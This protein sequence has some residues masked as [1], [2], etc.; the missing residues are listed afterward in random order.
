MNRLRTRNRVGLA[1]AAAF[2]PPPTPSMALSIGVSGVSTFS[3]TYQFANIVRHMSGWNRVSGSGSF[4][5][6]Q[7]EL[8][9][10]VATDFFCA[11]LAN[12]GRGLPSGTY[13]VKNPNGCKIGFGAFNEFTNPRFSAATPGHNA[14][15]F[16]GDFTFEWPG[17]QPVSTGL[18]LLC[19]G[20]VSGVEVL[21]PGH[22]PGE[23]FTSDF[24]AYEQGLGPM[25][26]IRV[27]T[28]MAPNFSVEED[29][30]DRTVPTK[31][32]FWKWDYTIVP[33][34]I[35]VQTAVRFN[36]DIWITVPMRAAN[37]AYANAMAAYFAANLPAH[38]KVWIEYTN[39]AWNIQTFMHATNWV[40]FHTHTKIAAAV[41]STT[42]IITKVAHGLVNDQI[43]RAFS[44][45][46][47][48]AAGINDDVAPTA[49]FTGGVVY[50]THKGDVCYAEVLTPDTFKLWSLP[51]AAAGG[52]FH[53][54]FS[55]GVTDCI[56]VVQDEPG[57]L[58]DLDVNFANASYLMW[59]AFDTAFGGSSR[60][61]AVMAGQVGNDRA[62]YRLGAA[63]PA[64]AAR[65]DYYAHAPYYYGF[66]WGGQV[67]VSSGQLMPKFWANNDNKDQGGTATG[68][69]GV[70]ALGSDPSD[71]E[72]MA[73]TGTGFVARATPWSRAPST[74][75][76]FLSA[77][78][79]VSGLP[80]G[81]TYTCVMA[82]EDP[83]GNVWSVKQN[84]EV[85]AV[86]SSVDFL[87]TYA[88]QAKRQSVTLE[89]KTLPNIADTKAGIALSTR[90]AIPLIDYEGGLHWAQ[91][92]TGMPAPLWNW[93]FNGYVE[94]QE[95]ADTFKLYLNTLAS[96]G[97]KLHSVFTDMAN[98][99]ISWTLASSFTDTTDKRYMAV[100]GLNG[101]VPITAKVSVA[102]IQ[103]TP[104][105]NQ[106]GGYP[107]VV[108]T[109]ADP[110]LTYT[111]LKEAA[112]WR[113]YV[114]V[115][116]E[117]RMIA[118]NGI[119]WLAPANQTI[120]VIASNGSTDDVFEVT[121]STGSAWYEGAAL[122]AVNMTTQGNASA[123]TMVVGSNNLTPATTPGTLSGG[124][125]NMT[126]GSNY[127]QS[128]ALTSNL[129]IDN[130]K[131]T[132]ILVVAGQ[133]GAVATNSPFFEIGSSQFC[134]LSTT[135]S[136]ANQLRWRLVGNGAVG[137]ADTTFAAFPWSAS[138][139][140]EWIALIPDENK[141]YFGT[142]Q[143]VRNVGGTFFDK[144]SG[145][146][147]QR[148]VALRPG[149]NPK[150]GSFEATQAVGMTL[151]DAKAMVQKV[152]TLHGIT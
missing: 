90:P 24:I 132:L 122:G 88:N 16:T 30:A 92:E 141:V 26:P 150:I 97:I 111:I 72:V 29:P 9:A 130:T 22:V 35:L 152:Q 2:P 139:A 8:V 71:G 118:G 91:A 77:A 79:A 149:S 140:V 11:P 45:K 57:K 21:L 151:A 20:S 41:N 38:L 48:K 133:G 64:A 134:N 34:E 131:G 68:H 61:V 117:L 76:L 114:I 60:V 103:G 42:N 144:W 50:K 36:R 18:F 115:G 78:A 10:S 44:S 19:Q 101:S 12:Q 56:Y 1:I 123:I 83:N 55:A 65:A 27:M 23:I 112:G 49:G 62:R 70:Y 15:Y 147:L 109:F 75:A 47:T 4:T 69:F 59:Q 120:R 98:P 96:Q 63:V 37:S 128:T 99:S 95:H 110:T 82:V 102:D 94:S 43:I 108:T 124:L 7:G 107:Q 40:T 33:W 74:S 129:T 105:P 25:S 14:G 73:G 125:L 89:N 143:T 66:F 142:N 31:M 127:I 116:N 86:A 136:N 58:V 146:T 53:V 81:T 17:A 138:L 126:G 148:R 67:D 13:T 39:E 52:G 100:A 84:V 28:W 135:T 85:S 32:S 87:D 80:N 54:P 46:A 121:S 119:D 5:Q 3:G 145:N 104:F 106:P 6:D 51:G 93:V 137:G 113:N